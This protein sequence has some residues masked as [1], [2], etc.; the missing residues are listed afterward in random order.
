MG[1]GPSRAP[2]PS[3]REY[4]P[5]AAR[6]YNLAVTRY[7]REFR[8]IQRSLSNATLMQSDEDFALDERTVLDKDAG[9]RF[10]DFY[11]AEG[12]RHALGRYG[13]L[14]AIARRGYPDVAIETRAEAERHTL[15][16]DGR[17]SPD[18]PY[19]RLLE[20][21]VRR[22]TL[23][24]APRAGLPALR[25][26]YDVLTIDWLML[27]RP[28]VRFSADRPPVPGQRHPGLGVGWR[29]LAILFRAVDRLGLDALATVADHLHNAEHYARELPFLDPAYAGK[30]RA[31]LGLLRGRHGL[32]TAQAS[33]AL[34]WGL[35]HDSAGEVVRWH[36]ELQ[37]GTE[38]ETLV[39]YFESGAY[40]SLAA[41][42]EE[43]CAR[44]EL[45]R[46]AFDA[47]WAAF[48]EDA[49]WP[50]GGARR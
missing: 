4:G 36:G 12:L 47:R 10:L 26:R 49:P 28:N 50:G 38:D 5:P 45:D 25:P 13:L 42:A 1:K 44:F 43:A 20:L 30:L 8:R 48:V 17:A 34:E 39:R 24:P 35:V 15:L 32:S 14:A 6:S 37:V 21:V 2:P 31:L 29:V 27:Q 41:V 23:V 9:R 33:W 18:E 46:R 40:A 3:R 11:G 16:L 22:D 19:T 7:D